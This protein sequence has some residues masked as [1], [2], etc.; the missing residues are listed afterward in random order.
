MGKGSALLHTL[1]GGLRFGSSY[2][3]ARPYCYWPFSPRPHIR[4]G[5]IKVEAEL[6]YRKRTVN[7]LRARLNTENGGLHYHLQ[8]KKQ[9]TEGKRFHGKIGTFRKK[10]SPQNIARRPRISHERSRDFFAKLSRNLDRLS[11][12]WISP[13]NQLRDKKWLFL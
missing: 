13:Q 6:S 9:R 7:Q 10:K 1:R 3:E 11:S 8:Q 5:C 2:N 12:D 4:K